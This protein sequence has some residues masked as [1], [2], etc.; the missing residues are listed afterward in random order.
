M[1]IADGKPMR[2]NLFVFK[3]GC[4]TIV[5]LYSFLLLSEMTLSPPACLRK[6]GQLCCLRM[7]YYLF[8]IL[9]CLMSLDRIVTF[10]P[11]VILSINLVCVAFHFKLLSS[12]LLL[13]FDSS[14]G[15]HL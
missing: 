9:Y 4:I 6:K 5:P 8:L 1:H 13:P 12:S 14:F 11:A 3:N 15:F 2:V 10:S 7:Y